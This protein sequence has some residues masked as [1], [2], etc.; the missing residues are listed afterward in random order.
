M[1]T[2]SQSEKAFFLRYCSIIKTYFGQWLDVVYSTNSQKDDFMNRFLDVSSFN[3]SDLKQVEKYIND[4]CDDLLFEL[5]S[6]A[7]SELSKIRNLNHTLFGGFL[8]LRLDTLTQQINSSS[9]EGI[10]IPDYQELY[11][12]EQQAYKRN[13]AFHSLS[14][15]F[16]QR[17]E[18]VTLVLL[19]LRSI[20]R[21]GKSEPKIKDHFRKLFEYDQQI[22]REFDAFSVDQDESTMP[23]FP[24][25]KYIYPSTSNPYES[26]FRE[27]TFIQQT[28]S[29][30]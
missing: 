4:L 16:Q 13:V 17:D 18:L 8:K 25:M 5:Q 26:L 11:S 7:I 12:I 3:L 10:T 22:M 24:V 2:A 6:C 23:F 9:G 15:L 19:L 30:V 14:M 20:Q 28:L 21:T 1:L 29:H 27:C